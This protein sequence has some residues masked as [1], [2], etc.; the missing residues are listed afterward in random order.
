M[1]RHSIKKEKLFVVYKVLR[2]AMT[3]DDIIVLK[4]MFPEFKDVTETTNDDE[5][6]QSIFKISQA[7]IVSQ[8]C[9]IEDAEVI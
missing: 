2:C 7:M 4:D 8:P 9:N 5:I 6:L 1:G 3:P